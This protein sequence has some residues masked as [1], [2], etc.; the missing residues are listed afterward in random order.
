MQ[1]DT[2]VDFDEDQVEYGDIYH[3]DEADANDAHDCILLVSR[4]SVLKGS[5]LSNLFCL[6]I[7]P[8]SVCCPDLSPINLGLRLASRK[9][10]Y[11]GGTDMQNVLCKPCAA[12]RVNYL[13]SGRFLV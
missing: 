5:F 3:V 10:R 11:R 12:L 9:Y 4:I 13:G 2:F 6:S 7:R 1:D 8:K